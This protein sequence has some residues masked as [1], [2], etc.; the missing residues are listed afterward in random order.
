MA[1]VESC[2]SRAVHW[3]DCDQSSSNAV[4]RDRHYSSAFKCSQT[5]LSPCRVA[6]EEEI[7]QNGSEISILTL[8]KLWD[9]V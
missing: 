6:I 4:H 1:G 2:T 8:I 7:T 5:L 9:C 3:N